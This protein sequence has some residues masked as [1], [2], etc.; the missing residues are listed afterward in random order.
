[1]STR[2]IHDV[3]RDKRWHSVTADTPIYDVARLMKSLPTSA[4]LV[5]DES[6]ALLGICTERDIVFRVLAEDRNPHRVTVGSVMTRQPRTIAVDRPLGHA[7]HLMYEGGFR[8]VP[9][10]DAAGKP[11]GI[12]AARDALGVEARQFEQELERREEITVIL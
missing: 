7:L 6:Q 2:A 4:V 1:M 5:V 8:H 11:V 10:V 3:I 9:V 12:V